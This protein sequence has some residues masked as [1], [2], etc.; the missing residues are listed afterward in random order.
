MGTGPPVFVLTLSCHAAFERGRTLFHLVEQGHRLPGPRPGFPGGDHRRGR[1]RAAP[2]SNPAMML[3]QCP[4]SCWR[5][6]AAGRVGNEV[7][8]GTRTKRTPFRTRPPQP[9]A[10]AQAP[11]AG[12]G[13][14]HSGHSGF[15][16]FCPGSGTT[17]RQYHHARFRQDSA[18]SDGGTLGRP[19]MHGGSGEAVAGRHRVRLHSG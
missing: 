8:L 19:R 16:L 10:A 14:H 15:R 6:Q 2:Q 5:R 1:R 4:A 3:H 13:T 18:V 17:K 9:A 7:N 11:G 12:R